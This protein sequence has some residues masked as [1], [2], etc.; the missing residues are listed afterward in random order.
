LKPFDGD[1]DLAGGQAVEI[2]LDGLAVDRQ[3]GG[4]ESRA[5][6]GLDETAA[7]E[8]LSGNEAFDFGLQHGRSP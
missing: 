8:R 4:R 2:G 6:R 5:E 1:R 3:H 7:V